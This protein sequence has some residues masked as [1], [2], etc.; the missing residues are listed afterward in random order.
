MSKTRQQGFITY[1]GPLKI[2]VQKLI[3]PACQTANNTVQPRL[4]TS[5]SCQKKTG[6]APELG[7][8]PKFCCFLPNLSWK[9]PYK[10]NLVLKKD[11][12]SLKFLGG[13]LL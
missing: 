6:S 13:V 5:Q 2:A 7:L 8:R 12:F 3:K 4:P 11:K 9:Q 10:R 1:L